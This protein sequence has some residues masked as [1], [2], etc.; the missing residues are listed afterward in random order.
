MAPPVLFLE[1]K[2]YS[3]SFWLQEFHFFL[4]DKSEYYQEKKV[5]EVSY[6]AKYRDLC[7]RWKEL[8]RDFFTFSC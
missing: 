6:G 3:V 8:Q 2:I 7:R 4:H 1:A 5:C